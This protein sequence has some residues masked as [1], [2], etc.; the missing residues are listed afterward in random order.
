MAVYDI[1]CGSLQQFVTFISVKSNI[2]S[3]LNN[4]DEFCY[5]KYGY[6]VASVLKSLWLLAMSRSVCMLDN[7]KEKLKND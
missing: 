2:R 1:L 7:Q 6:M 4:K 5:S 3:V